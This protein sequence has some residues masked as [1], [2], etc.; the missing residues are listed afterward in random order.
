MGE[1]RSQSF[2]SCVHMYLC[3]YSILTQC[4][5]L[6]DGARERGA[7]LC[8]CV[9]VCAKLGHTSTGSTCTYPYIV[10]LAAPWSPYRLT[11]T[12]MTLMTFPPLFPLGL[13]WATSI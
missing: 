1:G 5:G 8:A 6:K 10:D 11:V 4:G 9:C 3:V 7:G 2:L 13:S 12:V